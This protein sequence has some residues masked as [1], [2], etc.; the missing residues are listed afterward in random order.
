MQSGDLKVAGSP[1]TAF[2]RCIPRLGECIQVSKRTVGGRSALYHHQGSRLSSD[3]ER[4]ISKAVSRL[5]S[6]FW[7]EWVC[8]PVHQLFVFGTQGV[9]CLALRAAL[10]L[11]R[12]QEIV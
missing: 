12:L 9:Q 10:C 6:G 4:C 7:E 2:H 8:L 1:G 11:C 3:T 5:W